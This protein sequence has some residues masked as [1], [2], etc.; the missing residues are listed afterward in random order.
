[1]L[2]YVVGARHQNY[3]GCISWHRQEMEIIYWSIQERHFCDAHVV[4][5]LDG[6]TAVLEYYF[7]EL[8]M[9]VLG[10]V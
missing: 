4:Q 7:G 8:F 10:S 6:G 5:H 3:A 9:V 1:M 2:L